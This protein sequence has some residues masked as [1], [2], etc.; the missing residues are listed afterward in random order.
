MF[1]WKMKEIKKMDNLISWTDSGL[2]FIS[3]LLPFRE[4]FPSLHSSTVASKPGL[5]LHRLWVI[6]LSDAWS[7]LCVFIYDDLRQNS[8]DRCCHLR[9]FSTMIW[10]KH[11]QKGILV[12]VSL[13]QW[14]VAN[15]RR[16]TRRRM[17]ICFYYNAFKLTSADGH[18]HLGVFISRIWSKHCDKFSRLHFFV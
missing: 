14:F 13:I 1:E 17:S 4:V 5:G 6:V 2:F 16:R 12:Y 9:I 18:S 15:I 10:N 7:R 8:A 3:M 11:P